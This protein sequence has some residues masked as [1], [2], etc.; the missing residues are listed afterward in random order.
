MPLP[1]LLMESTALV[2]AWRRCVQTKRD[3]ASPWSK[4]KG[5][6]AAIVTTLLQKGRGPELPWQRKA[7]FGDTIHFIPQEAPLERAQFW[8]ESASG[9]GPGWQ[10]CVLAELEGTFEQQIWK[11]QAKQHLCGK[12]FEQGADLTILLRLIRKH[13][14]AQRYR[15]AALL[16]RIATGA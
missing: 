10:Q 4:V 5:P 9:S 8:L 13:W 3:A 12:G 16:A 2:S 11:D 6:I 14:G 15:H 7:P 1:T